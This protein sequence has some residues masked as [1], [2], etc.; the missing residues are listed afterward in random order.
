[1][2]GTPNDEKPYICD[3]DMRIEIEEREEQVYE[4]D[5]TTPMTE[6]HEADEDTVD[7]THRTRVK[8]KRYF[9]RL[10]VTVM[11]TALVFD[12]SSKV[13]KSIGKLKG[14]VGFNITGDSG[15]KYL[16]SDERVTPV[17]LVVDL[18][19]LFQTW[20]GFGPWQKVPKSWKLEQSTEKVVEGTPAEDGDDI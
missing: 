15:V 2:A 17:N 12:G 13:G 5:G 1:M 10:V 7:R 20:S 3:I 11:K 4:D 9:Y 8:L 19:R 16:C 6:Q 14:G 18:W